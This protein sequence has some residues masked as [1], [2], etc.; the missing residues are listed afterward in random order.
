MVASQGSK[1]KPAVRENGVPRSM[2]Q[3]CILGRVAHRIRP[4]SSSKSHLNKAEEKQFAE[5]LEITYSIEYGKT[6]KQ[7]MT[8]VES[9]PRKTFAEESR[10]MQRSEFG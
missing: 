8:I 3:G 2:L 9:C 7:V 5:F 4:V 6:Q 1:M 10:S